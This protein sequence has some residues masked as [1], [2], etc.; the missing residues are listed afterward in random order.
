MKTPKGFVISTSPA[1]GEKVKRDATI[2]LLIS[3]GVETFDVAS[4]VGKSADQALN[5][6]TEAGFD[7]DTVSQYSE[8][9]PGEVISQLPLG[10]APLEKGAKIT[11]TISKGSQ[12]VA[13][14]NVFNS[15]E[16]EARA[17]LN[18]LE[19]KVVVKKI[20][21]KK[22]KRVINISPKEGTKV[23]R[24]STVTITVG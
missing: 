10:G 8:K 9:D 3:K 15:T 4:Y 19:L 23:K 24:G 20:G 21:A 6:L 22:V 2:D 18:D 16:A 5:E 14:P 1:A 13:I 12:Y 11:L 7:V 17:A